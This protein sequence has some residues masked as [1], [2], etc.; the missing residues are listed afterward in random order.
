MPV[1]GKPRKYF[2]KFKFLVE[3]DNVAVAGFQKAGP[4]EAEVAVVEQNEGGTLLPEKEPGRGKF[5]DI[6]LARGATDDLDMWRWF[7]EVL[8]AAANAGLSTPNYKRNL[9]I[10]QQDRDGTTLRRWRVYE[11]FPTKFKAGEWDNDA[12][13]NVIEETVLAIRY[14]EPIAV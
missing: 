1:V 11:A 14:F 3:I 6:T 7:K 9:D 13:E 4:L 10:V 5:S 2:K 8:D 12:D